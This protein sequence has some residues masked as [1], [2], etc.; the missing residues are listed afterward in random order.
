ML[1]KLEKPGFDDNIL[2]HY[3]SR[4]NVLSSECAS[5]LMKYQLSLNTPTLELILVYVI[6]PPQEHFPSLCKNE[7]PIS[8][9]RKMLTHFSTSTLRCCKKN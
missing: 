3:A 2:N 4:L 5:L 8:S 7:E 9:K 1:S 6:S